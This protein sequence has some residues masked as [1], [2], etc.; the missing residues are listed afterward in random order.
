MNILRKISL[1]FIS[2]ILLIVLPLNTFIWTTHQTLLDRNVILGWLKEGNVY[3]NIADTAAKIAEDSLNNKSDINENPEQQNSG[4]GD[5]PDTATLIKA[6]K[7]ALP[8]NVLQE[9]VETVINSSYDW[10]EGKTSTIVLNL[11]LADEKKAFINALGNEAITRAAS[12]PTCTAPLDKDFNPLSSDC[13]P[14]GSDVAAQAEKIKNDLSTKDDFI[15]NTKITSADLKVGDENNKKLFTEEF[16]YLPKAYKQVKNSAFIS[17]A[18]VGV[19]GLLVFLL[20]KTRQ[21]GLKINAW[22][23]GLSGLWAL[24]IGSAFKFANTSM[25]NQLLNDNADASVANT[26]IATLVS[27]VASTLFKWHMIIGGV[28]LGVAVISA[29]AIKSSNKKDS[30][31]TPKSPKAEDK[32]PVAE[33]SKPAPNVSAKP[34]AA[35]RP[36]PTKSPKRQNLVQ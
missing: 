29:V 15:P 11:D 22:I 18:T 24:L 28:Y 1:F 36:Q 30:Q 4:E 6:A 20:G 26:A 9:D 32:P 12:L 5:M 21:S 16:S 14:S 17:A 25:I 13:V 2:L 27:E 19:L 34:V 33:K 3:D 35:N 8:P 7:A 31:E 10:L 23:F